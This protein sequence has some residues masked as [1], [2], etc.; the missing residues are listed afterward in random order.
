MR[1]KLIQR[2]YDYWKENDDDKS[3]LLKEITENID[4]GKEGANTL[5]EWCLCD[6]DMAKER[7]AKIHNITE[8]E[9]QD[10]IESSYGD[11]SFMRNDIDYLEDLDEIW[12]LCNWYL[13]YCDGTMS[14][15]DLL[16]GMEIEV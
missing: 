10:F 11:L 9:L 4:S 13:D 12:N 2:L 14:E 7:Y 1:E 15:K 8:E 5:I 16:K 3:T 6:Y